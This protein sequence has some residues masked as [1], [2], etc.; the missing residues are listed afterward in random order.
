MEYPLLLSACR[1]GAFGARHPYPGG[2]LYEAGFIYL[3]GEPD[4]ALPGALRERWPNRMFVCLSEA[5]E[6][7]L[8]EAYPDLFRTRRYQMAYIPDAAKAQALKACIH[9]LPPEYRLVPFDE[10]IFA[11]QPFGHGRNYPDY[12]AFRQYGAGFAVRRA[13]DIVSVASS[14]LSHQGAVEL[15][16]FTLPGHRKKGLGIA[17]C[18]EML[19][20]CQRRDIAVHWDAQNIASRSMAERLGYALEKEYDAYSFIQPNEP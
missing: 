19:L 8:L 2:C 13:N 9:R 20:D 16:V 5:W 6:K 14:F 15:D 12:A 7:A 11:R 10:D 4:A 17:C 1:A 18:A 3:E